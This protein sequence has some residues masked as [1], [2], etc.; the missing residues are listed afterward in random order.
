MSKAC[1]SIGI[2]QSDRHVMVMRKVVRDVDYLLSCVAEGVSRDEAK[3]YND[4]DKL[5]CLRS[6][7]QGVSRGIAVVDAVN[8]LH[9]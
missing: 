7:F 8:S 9:V 5:T 1:T 3:T 4:V 6:L 2:E